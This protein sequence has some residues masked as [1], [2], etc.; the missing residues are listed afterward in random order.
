MRMYILLLSE[1]CVKVIHIGTCTFNIP[2]YNTYRTDHLLGPSGGKTIIIRG[3]I[4][5]V[6]KPIEK[7]SKSKF[8][9]L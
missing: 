1:T 9:M 2:D 6:I 3:S 7:F 4:S 8:F 5:V